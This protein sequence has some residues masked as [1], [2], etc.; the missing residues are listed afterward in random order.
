MP[1]AAPL[2][3]SIE[4]SA[5]NLPFF[6]NSIISLF[7]VWEEGGL[8]VMLWNRLVRFQGGRCGISFFCG[9]AR[10]A[11]CLFYSAAESQPNRVAK[12]INAAASQTGES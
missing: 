7:K 12:S 9:G 3:E 4:N 5:T 10:R 6:V 2:A 8:I 1:K 11:A